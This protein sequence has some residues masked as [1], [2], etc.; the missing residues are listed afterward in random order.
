M[1]HRIDRPL[2][3][4]GEKTNTQPDAERCQNGFSGGDARF[5]AL[6]R[7]ADHALC[8][9]HIGLQTRQVCEHLNLN[10]S[11]QHQPDLIMERSELRTCLDTASRCSWVMATVIHGE[12]Q[13]CFSALRDSMR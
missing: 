2:D 8:L 10:L 3:E 7:T 11:S 4:I 9:G 12:G 6:H 13:S 5:D 1:I